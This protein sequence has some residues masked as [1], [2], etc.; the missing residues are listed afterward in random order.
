MLSCTDRQAESWAVRSLDKA[1]RRWCLL[2]ADQMNV[3]S[4][5][6]PHATISIQGTVTHC[7]T[8]PKKSRHGAAFIDMK[9]ILKILHVCRRFC[10]LTVSDQAVLE[11]ESLK[12]L[13]EMQITQLSSHGGFVLPSL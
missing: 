3:L 8:V 9:H 7:K 11:V 2:G 4:T 6:N 1:H 5:G 13:F 10:T 12:V